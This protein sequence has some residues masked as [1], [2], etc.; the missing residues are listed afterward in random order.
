[1]GFCLYFQIGLLAKANKSSTTQILLGFISWL[2]FLFFPHNNSVL[3]ES[4]LKKHFCAQVGKS[5]F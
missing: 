5:A 1:M 2:V 3:Q 4:V